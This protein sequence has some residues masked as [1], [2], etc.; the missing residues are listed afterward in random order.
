[1][2]VLGLL[3]VGSVHSLFVVNGGACSGSFF[4]AGNC[5]LG[6]QLRV[7]DL[8]TI[9]SAVVLGESLTVSGSV[10]VGLRG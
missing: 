8:T 2:S 3:R 10:S 9:G 1:M 4:V 7:P 5:D 6:S